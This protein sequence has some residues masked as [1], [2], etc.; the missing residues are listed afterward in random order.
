MKQNA[1]M[2]AERNYQKTF[3]FIVSAEAMKKWRTVLYVAMTYGIPC[4]KRAGSA[5][6]GI[7]NKSQKNWK[8]PT[9]FFHYQQ[10][11]KDA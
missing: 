3:I 9:V 10:N 6:M 8:S 5:V 2:I 11:N 4:K 1:T 7:V